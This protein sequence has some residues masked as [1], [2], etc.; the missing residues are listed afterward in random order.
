VVS[1]VNEGVD[2]IPC[3]TASSGMGSRRSSTSSKGG[4]R[5]L[6]I[7]GR[8]ALRLRL[9]ALICCEESLSNGVRGCVR[10]REGMEQEGR[11]KVLYRARIRRRSMTRSAG[12]RV[13][14]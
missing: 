2:E 12:L 9:S 1:G 4:E 10:G 5:R 7:S 3:D 11:R 8:R 13:W 6:E 14:N